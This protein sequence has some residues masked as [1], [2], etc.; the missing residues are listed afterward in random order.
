LK[1]KSKE[2]A[3]RPLDIDR[4]G[5]DVIPERE[6]L[7]LILLV[8]E[9]RGSE[10]VVGID[11]DVSRRDYFLKL[12]T[13]DVALIESNG[14]VVTGLE[15]HPVDITVV[16]ADLLQISASEIP[17]AQIAIHESGIGDLGFPKVIR[18][19][20]AEDEVNGVDDLLSQIKSREVTIVKAKTANL[21]HLF[22]VACRNPV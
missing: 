22:Q 8:L 13:V 21:E 17:A 10:F 4:D 5:A 7:L 9:K 16:D 2:I 3:K 18:S 12:G 15:D 19:E 20:E 14:L 11:N 6:N 1:K